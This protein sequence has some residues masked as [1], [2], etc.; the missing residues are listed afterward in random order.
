MPGG[1]WS[2]HSRGSF[3]L[4]DQARRNAAREARLG[5]P[6]THAAARAAQTPSP[7]TS[8]GA[9]SLPFA[10]PLQ[11]TPKAGRSLSH[12][13][14][15]RELPLPSPQAHIAGGEQQIPV[16]PLGLLAETE[17]ADTETESELG[18]PITQTYS[19]PPIGSLQRTSTYPNHY[20]TFHAS[21][22]IN[23]RRADT[24]SDAIPGQRLDKRFEAAFADLNLGESFPFERSFRRYHACKQAKHT[25]VT[26]IQ[27]NRLVDHSGKHH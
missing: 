23:N 24:F 7:A 13:Q 11:P 21:N 18:T 19:H 2:S 22:N 17:E 3:K 25:N 6:N 14:G 12:S 8:E 4:S 27:I 9:A 26:R 20:D 16:L 15:Q 1:I 5:A 10:I